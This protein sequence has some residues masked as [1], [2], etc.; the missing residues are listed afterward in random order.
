MKRVLLFVFTL[1]LSV[2]IQ[3][4]FNESAPWMKMLNTSNRSSENPLKFQQIV[5]AF[6]NYWLTHDK[7]QKGSGYKPFKRWEAYW[8]NF[9][10]EDGTLP[11][12]EELWNT[13]Q[14]VQNQSQNLRSSNVLI[15]ESNWMPIGPFTH[16]NTGSWSSGQGRVNVIVK[17][18]NNPSTFYEF[19][20]N[21]CFRN[22]GRCQ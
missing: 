21:R 5:D 20:S 6:N 9:V 12:S 19:T 2:S 11:T 4:Q 15:D 10:K 16:T 18:P 7:N 14:L 17:D 13:Y 22:C 8:S 3:A 1:L